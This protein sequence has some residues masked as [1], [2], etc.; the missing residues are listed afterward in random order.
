MRKPG[1][2][3]MEWVSPGKRRIYAGLRRVLAEMS[4]KIINNIE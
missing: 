2:A 3:G 1:N 4:R